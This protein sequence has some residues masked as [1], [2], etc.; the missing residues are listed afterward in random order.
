[1]VLQTS[2]WHKFIYQLSLIILNAVTNQFY[3]VFML[4]VPKKAD[5]RHP[6]FVS[7]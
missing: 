2:T 4:Q 7:L 5:L 6:L 3:Q 1:M